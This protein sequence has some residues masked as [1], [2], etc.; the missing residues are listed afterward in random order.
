MALSRGML[1]VLL[2]FVGCSYQPET[3]ND[4]NEG[5]LILA[6]LIFTVMCSLTYMAKRQRDRLRR[7][8]FE[9]KE[10]IKALKKLQQRFN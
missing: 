7:I 9:R 5:R 3:N 6:V 1:L 4:D 8:E 10:R 2:F